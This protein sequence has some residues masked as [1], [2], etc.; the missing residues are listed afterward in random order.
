MVILIILPL[1]SPDKSLK[2][3]SKS[4]AEIHLGSWTILPCKCRHLSLGPKTVLSC[5]CHMRVAW[6][7][8]SPRSSEGQVLPQLKSCQGR[9]CRESRGLA[10][11]RDHRNSSKGTA[12]LGTRQGRS[13][14]VHQQGTG[15][16]GQ[17]ARAGG[18]SQDKDWDKVRAGAM[19]RG[20]PAP[21]TAQKTP[22]RGQGQL[23]RSVHPHLP[24]AGQGPGMPPG[25]RL[26]EQPPG[27]AT[28]L[29]RARLGACVCPFAGPS[30]SGSPRPRKPRRVPAQPRSRR[31]SS[32]PGSPAAR[33][34]RES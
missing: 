6:G 18:E 28:P 14:I 33:T 30:G 27:T 20:I 10:G 32:R 34:R 7:R 8:S 31:G 22:W 15:E 29:R 24:A 4:L 19:E 3:S 1:K 5:H 26:A 16:R 17:K 12:R 25:Q 2:N 9:A 11:E 23:G 21:R 13:G